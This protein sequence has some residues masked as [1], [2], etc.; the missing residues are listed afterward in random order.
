MTTPFD[1]HATLKQILN[2]ISI[3]TNTEAQSAPAANVS[4]FNSFRG[5]SLLNKLPF[6]TCEEAGIPKEYCACTPPVAYTTNLTI[7]RM[8]AEAVIQNINS[9]LPTAC[10]QLEVASVF[11]A[12]TVNYTLNKNN[13][14]RSTVNFLVSLLTYPGKFRYEALVEFDNAAGKF[15]RIDNILR[16]NTKSRDT[17]CLTYK[18]ASFE[19]KCYCRKSIFSM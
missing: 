11:A 5:L 17:D 4:Q 18:Q 3:T 10:S 1:I 2:T 13:E 7:V 12:A 16:T 14:S 15:T 9:E 19:L 6:R 8:A